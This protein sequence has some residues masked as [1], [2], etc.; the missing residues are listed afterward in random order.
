MN[1]MLPKGALSLH[2]TPQDMERG[3]AISRMYGGHNLRPGYMYPQ[4]PYSLAGLGFTYWDLMAGSGEENCSP[5]DSACVERNTQRANAVEDLWTTQYMRDP[6]TANM[7][8]PKISVAVDS[9]ASAADAMWNNQPEYASSITSNGVAYDPR[10]LEQ[11]QQQQQQ[12]YTASGGNARI[13]FRTSTGDTGQLKPGNTWV[14]QIT[15]AKA[16]SPVVVAGGQNGRNDVTNMG[17]TDGAGGWQASGT[18][19]AGMVGNWNESWS[20][21]GVNVGTIAFT[22]IA[23]TPAQQSTVTGKP[24]SSP[25]P[26]NQLVPGDP[27]FSSTHEK[28]IGGGG[29]AMG[30]FGAAEAG[31]SGGGGSN[32]LLL[33]AAGLAAVYLMSKK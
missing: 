14:I 2:R 21:G 15:G 30:S 20:V 4:G 16:N 12:T 19:E 26:G 11:G 13:S 23:A 28:L 22:V 3:S 6:N 18:I 1:I 7:A 33:I 25:P 32:S 10:T 29:A 17:N 8:A 5:R 27:G 31:W 24:N 9:S